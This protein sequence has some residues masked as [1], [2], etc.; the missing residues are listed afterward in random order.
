MKPTDKDIKEIKEFVGEYFESFVETEEILNSEGF[1]ILSDAYISKPRKYNYILL[2]VFLII[3]AERLRERLEMLDDYE[4]EIKELEEE[5][6]DLKSKLRDQDPRSESEIVYE[7]M[8]SYTNLKDREIEK[9]ISA[10]YRSDKNYY[11]YDP[12]RLRVSDPSSLA[13]LTNYTV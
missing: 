7:F 13:I 6:K 4:A 11:Y 3:M 10:A 1:N 9:L 8:K 2:S 5:I 12:P